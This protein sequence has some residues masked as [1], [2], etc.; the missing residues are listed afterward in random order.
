MQTERQ[1]TADPHRKPTDLGCELSP[2][3]G[4]FSLHPLLQL[5]LLSP[6]TDSYFTVCGA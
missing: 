3:V 1:A 6:K 4:C 2:P 5:L